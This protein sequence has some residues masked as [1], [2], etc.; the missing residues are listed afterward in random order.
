MMHKNSI[1]SDIVSAEVNLV[2]DL[3]FHV[4]YMLPPHNVHSALIDQIGLPPYYGPI[5]FFVT[6]FVVKFQEL[7]VL[8]GKTIFHLRGIP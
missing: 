1:K 7:L 8:L 2:A 6:L 4:L 5:P 3:P